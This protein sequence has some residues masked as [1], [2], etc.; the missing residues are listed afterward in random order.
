MLD[1]LY[2]RLESLE[3]DNKLLKAENIKLH[4]RITRL[5]NKC[6]DFEETLI[7]LNYTVNKK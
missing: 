7:D 3:Q 6:V 4:D 1:D 2:E 5:E